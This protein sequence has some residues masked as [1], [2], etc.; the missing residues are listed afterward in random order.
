MRIVSIIAAV[1]M[2]S[3][4]RMEPTPPLANPKAEEKA[5]TERRR[6]E[7]AEAR[8]REEQARTTRWQFAVLVTLGISGVALV[9][10]II[11]G[12]RARHE[13]EK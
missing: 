2:F 11:I 6:L 4:C 8:L 3:S 12:S 13:T 7:D 9:V 5:A 1:L 10:G